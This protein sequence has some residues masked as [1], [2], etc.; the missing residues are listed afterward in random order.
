MKDQNI[1]VSLLLLV[2]QEEAEI[3]EPTTLT[4]AQQKA[5]SIMESFENPFRMVR[6]MWN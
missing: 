3:P 2:L 1:R 6:C 4:V 5:R